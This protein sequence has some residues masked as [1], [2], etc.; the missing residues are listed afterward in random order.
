MDAMRNQESRRDQGPKFE[1]RAENATLTALNTSFWATCALPVMRIQSRTRS[2]GD[3]INVD[4]R[5]VPGRS[6]LVRTNR[7]MILR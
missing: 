4:V 1:A 5:C 2:S 3:R 6:R 7:S